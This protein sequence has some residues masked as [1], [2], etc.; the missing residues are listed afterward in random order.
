[1][2]NKP[3]YLV[4][5]SLLIGLSCI[6]CTLDEGNPGSSDP[7]LTLQVHTDLS[8]I[9]LEWS[10]VK[11]TGFKEYI[12]LQ[13]TGDIPNAPTP[14]VDQ[15]ITVLTRTNDI[16]NTT[17]ST[18]N[19]L[20]SPTSCFKLYCSVD[21]RFMYSGTVCINQSPVLL[22]GFYDRVGHDVDLPQIAMFD[23]VNLRLTAF[24]DT[25]ASIYNSIEENNLTFP[26]LDLSTYQGTNRLF[27]FDLSTSQ[28]RKYSFPELTLQNQIN[29]S[30]TIVGGVAHDNL[31]FLSLQSNFS[32]FQVLNAQTLSP[33]DSKTGLSGSRNLAV[34]PGDPQVVLEISDAAINRY[35]INSLGKVITTDQFITGVNQPSSQNTCDVNSNYYIGGRFATM[36]NKEAEVVTS[37]ENGIN[38]FVQLSRFSPDGTQ[39]AVIS[40]NN[41]AVNLELF[42]IT[43]LPAAMLIKSYTLPNASFS[44]LFFRDEVINVIGVSF[45]SSSPQTFFLKFPM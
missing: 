1:M 37:L 36:V 14:T 44:D 2:K 19:V 21:D 39:A 45:N 7:A 11:V 30:Q 35:E 9:N 25:D 40:N 16:N 18:T 4:L 34:F 13:S 8:L 38:A 32:G 28:I 17:F 26:Q 43:N 29:I 3:F 15:D 5:L 33:L 31:V 27:T 6:R 23:R 42:D 20:F 10:P 41:N 22:P 24:T 12:I